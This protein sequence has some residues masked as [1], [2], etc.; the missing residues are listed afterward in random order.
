MERSSCSFA[1]RDWRQKRMYSILLMLWTVGTLSDPTLEVGWSDVMSP[2]AGQFIHKKMN[3][4][5]SVFSNVRSTVNDQFKSQSFVSFSKDKKSLWETLSF[6]FRWKKELTDGITDRADLAQYAI[7]WGSCRTRS[8]HL[9][10]V[11]CSTV[12]LRESI[13]TTEFWSTSSSE[14]VW[15]Y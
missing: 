1:L 10:C 12:L 4:R 15:F 11:L 13:S 6:V 14:Q 8:H 5:H 9:D 3:K 7:L 2:A